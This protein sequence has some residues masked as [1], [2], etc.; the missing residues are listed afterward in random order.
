MSKIIRN[1]VLWVVFLLVAP[2]IALLSF[3]ASRKDI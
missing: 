1:K 2:V 3:I